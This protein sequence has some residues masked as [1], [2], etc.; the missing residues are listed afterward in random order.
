MDNRVMRM[1][2]PP[3]RRACTACA[4][5]DLR[6]SAGPVAGDQAVAAPT[7]VARGVRSLRGRGQPLSS[8]LRSFYEPRFGHSFENVRLHTDANSGEIAR[9]IHARAFAYGNDIAF[10]PGEYQPETRQGQWLL[11]HELAHVVQASTGAAQ[12]TVSWVLIKTTEPAGGCGICFKERYPKNSVAMVG[13]EAHKAVQ[14]TISF[15]DGSIV[16]EF[17]AHSKTS[18]VRPD[19]VWGTR[20]GLEMA[21]IKPATP[22][23][24][25]GI[26]DLT[27][28]LK[29]LQMQFPM[30]TVTLRPVEPGGTIV[31]TDALASLAGC[32]LQKLHYQFTAP[33]FIQYWCDPPFSK[34]R[35]EVVP[36]N[37]TVS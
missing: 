1:S 32:K 37:W 9:K 6:R 17:M 5:Q 21:E 33:G 11:A 18:D 29:W 3:L 12:D 4:E 8:S 28:R 16:P 14:R 19:L 2:A 13:S 7:D 24:S 10:A 27:K 20:D 22:K 25:Q 23:G 34:A 30:S 35:S 26:S 36:E 15:W 31:M